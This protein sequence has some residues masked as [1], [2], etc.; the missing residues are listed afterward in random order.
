MRARGSVWDRPLAI[1]RNA[2][3]F[4]VGAG[5]LTRP[6]SLC[7]ELEPHPP[8]RRA[9]HQEKHRL[10]VTNLSATAVIEEKPFS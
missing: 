1:F 5:V 9:F 3:P 2:P 7:A 6:P 8:K 4:F 10:K